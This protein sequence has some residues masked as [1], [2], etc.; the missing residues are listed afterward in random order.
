MTTIILCISIFLVIIS[1]SYSV[2]DWS[3][4]QKLTGMYCTVLVM[5]RMRRRDN[6]VVNDDKDETDI[7]LKRMG[8]RILIMMIIIMIMIITLIII[9]YDDHFIYYNL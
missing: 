8:I 6:E 9:T 5:M 1:A 4:Q 3:F 2:F 7:M